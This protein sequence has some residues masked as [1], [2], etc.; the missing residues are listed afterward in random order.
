M[1]N[2]AGGAGSVVVGGGLGGAIATIISWAAKQF[3][4]IDMPPEVAGAFAFV[5]VGLGSWIGSKF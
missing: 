2:G 1:S 3:F 5:L 4:Q